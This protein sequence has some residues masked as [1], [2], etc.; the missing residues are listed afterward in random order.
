SVESLAVQR[1]RETE[2]HAFEIACQRRN[3]IWNWNVGRRRIVWITSS[4]DT[5]DARHVLHF[6]RKQAD[7]VQRRRKR[8]ET[9]TRVATIRRFQSH[10]TAERRRLAHGTAGV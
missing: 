2:P 7:L 9:V 5:Q 4:H 10:D 6:A 3:V 8:H 1:A